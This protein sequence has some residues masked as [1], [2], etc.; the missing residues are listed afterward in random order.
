MRY[1][2]ILTLFISLGLSACGPNS[3]T[4][5]VSDNAELTTRTDQFQAAAV[6]GPKL[7]VVGNRGV[8]LESS[9]RG[10]NWQRSQLPEL[11]PLIDISVCPDEHFVALDF[12][13]RVWIQDG[14]QAWH[15][16]QAFSDGISLALTCDSANNLWVVGEYAQILTSADLGKTWRNVSASDEDLILTDIQ[17]INANRAI[18][19]GEFGTQ[20]VT[21]NGGDSWQ[22]GAEIA[23][24]FYPQ[25]LY[26]KNEQQGWVT[27]VSGTI[28]GTTD[29]GN[30]WQ[31]QPTDTNAPLFNLVP[32]SNSVAAVGGQGT[33]LHLTNQQ[34]HSWT[35]K[36]PFYCY[37]RAAVDIGSDQLLIAGGNG[38]LKIVEPHNSTLTTAKIAGSAS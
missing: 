25:N 13:G 7:V 10:S 37:L 4:D 5:T 9:D 11:P 33:V 29:G 15:S 34:W 20:F 35:P 24:E 1:R 27:S 22:L 26:F 36:E 19:V 3:V 16:E 32:L 23:E 31:L 14:Q 38:C 28:Y 12:R 30:S 21:E 17:F 18:A 2:S 6:L 8:W